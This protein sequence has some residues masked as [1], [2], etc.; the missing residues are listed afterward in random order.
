MINFER[1][2]LVHILQK[3]SDL[4]TKEKNIKVVLDCS[5]KNEQLSEALFDI[6]KILEKSGIN[7]L[8]SNNNNNIVK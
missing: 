3:E 6:N 4:E 2:R 7:N 5:N 1:A 8:N